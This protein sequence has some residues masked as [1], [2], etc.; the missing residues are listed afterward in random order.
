MARYFFHLHTECRIE[1]DFVGVEYRSLEAAVTDA[2][3]ALTEYMRD[4]GIEG[5]RQ[6]RR[7]RFEITDASTRYVATVPTADN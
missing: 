1:P 2:R 6:Q 4:E 7:C 5:S 3:Q